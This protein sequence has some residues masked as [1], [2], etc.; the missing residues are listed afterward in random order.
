MGIHL[1]IGEVDSRKDGNGEF[2][3]KNIQLKEPA[4]YVG[5]MKE[6]FVISGKPELASKN[7]HM[8]PEQSIEFICS[9]GEDSYCTKFAVF[10]FR[11]ALVEADFPV[12]ADDFEAIAVYSDMAGYKRKTHPGP[13]FHGFLQ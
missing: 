11:Y 7:L 2:S 4:G 8:T 9:G 5:K 12:Q 13:R 1:D 6:L 10:G 3:Q